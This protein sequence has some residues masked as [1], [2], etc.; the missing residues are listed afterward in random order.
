MSFAK[1]ASNKIKSYLKPI[2]E[3]IDLKKALAEQKAETNKYK[4]MQLFP[5]GHFYSPILDSSQAA[6]DSS[7]TLEQVASANILFNLE[8]QSS[9]LFSAEFKKIYEMLPFSDKNNGTQRYFYENPAYSYSDGIFL[10][11]FLNKFKP[12][13]IIEVGSGYSSALIL[14]TNASYLKNDLEITFIEPYPDLLLSLMTQE[15][16]QK[17]QII[18]KN[19]QDVPLSRFSCL[20]ENDILFIDSTHVA[21]SGSDVNYIFSEILPSLNNGVLIHFHDIFHTFEY[22]KNWLEEGRNWNEIYMLRSFMQYNSHFEI[23]MFN[24]LLN[25]VFENE[26]ESQYPLMCKNKGGSIW[27]RKVA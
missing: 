4:D 13:R 16:K 7:L 8:A 5:P 22:P 19:L 11:Y 12:K 20:A 27:I 21:K 14:D 6:T 24:N 18:D 10:F 15:D 9:L 23:V 25:S 3:I 2:A 17:A 26:I 1:K